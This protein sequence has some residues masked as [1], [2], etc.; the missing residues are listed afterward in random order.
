MRK[1]LLLVAMLCSLAG[2]ATKIPG[3]A[4]QLPPES[5]ANRQLQTRRYDTGNTQAVLLSSAAVLQ[6]LGFNLDE[7]EPKLGVVVAS[8][9]RD[10]TNGGEVFFLALLG[11]LGNNPNAMNAAD[12]TQ[13]VKVSLVVRS[14]NPESEDPG[15]ALSADNITEIRN[16][17]YKSIYAGL[18]QKFD[19]NACNS[20]AKSIADDTA[21]TLK[22]DFGTLIAAKDAPG[23]TAV[24]VT[25]QQV[26]FNQVGQ[27]NSQQQIND[28]EI[29]R[30]FFEKL[31][32]SLF[33]E[34][35]AI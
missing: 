9:D 18:Q 35:N 25:F 23:V 30:E 28:P 5:L 7:T 17:V 24:R 15:A 4:L 3:A 16:S 14:L 26:I 1:T 6:D 32:K 31:S 21:D 33:L 12:A 11:A 13:L 34:A 27:I 10:A 19:K 2:C 20:V 29:Y 22:N 8:K